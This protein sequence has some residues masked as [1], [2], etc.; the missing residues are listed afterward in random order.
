MLKVP[1]IAC[2]QK[3]IF[4]NVKCSMYDIPLSLIIQNTDSNTDSLWTCT[5]PHICLC[6]VALPVPI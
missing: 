2:T 3:Y 4:N 5:G 6:A 1:C